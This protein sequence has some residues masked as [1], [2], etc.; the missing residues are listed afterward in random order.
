MAI[1]HNQELMLKHVLIIKR[2]TIDANHVLNAVQREVLINH[3]AQNTSHRKYAR[4][5][6]AQQRAINLHVHII[7]CP[8][9]VQNVEVREVIRRPVLNISV[10]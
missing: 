1:L 3:S 10:T 4:N 2:E 5:V 7:R 6:A 9:L 8:N